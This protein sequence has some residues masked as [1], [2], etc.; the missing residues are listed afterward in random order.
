MKTIKY[1]LNNFEEAILIVLLPLMCIVVF[2]AT[3]FRF[4]GW[5]I[6]PWAEE[7]ARYSMIWMVFL[8][9]SA[10]AKMGMHFCVTAVTDLLPP[11]GR[12]IMAIVRT[13]ILVAFNGFVAYHCMVILENQMRSGQ[14]TPS[15][16]WPMWAIYISIP[17]GLVLMA[18]RY[19]WCTFKE[20][21]DRTESKP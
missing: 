16:Q 11:L 21:T 15:L 14:T 5:V 3:F 10:G 7:L 17:I 13:V 6:L 8:G 2:M 9:I 20:V 1:L 19:S 4:T 12:K 18:V